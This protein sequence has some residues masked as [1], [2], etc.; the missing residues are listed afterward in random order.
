[1]YLAHSACDIGVVIVF[2]YFPDVKTVNGTYLDRD[3]VRL[4]RHVCL[5]SGVQVRVNV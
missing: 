2:R 1:M 4:G 3:E 5:F